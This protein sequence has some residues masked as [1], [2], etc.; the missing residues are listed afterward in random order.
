[1]KGSVNLFMT[2]KNMFQ[3]RKLIG[4]ERIIEYNDRRERYIKLVQNIE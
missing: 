3:S 1:M 2:L 4:F